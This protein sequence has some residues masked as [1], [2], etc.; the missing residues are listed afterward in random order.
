MRKFVLTMWVILFG[1]CMVKAE[2]W[3]NLQNA[4]SVAQKEYE[5][6][7]KIL[8]SRD[9]KAYYIFVN[10][11]W[12]EAFNGAE[13]TL[14]IMYPED[15]FKYIKARSRLD[16]LLYLNFIANINKGVIA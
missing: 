5:E 10:D 2:G 13:K 14:R 1:F 9:E 16:E 8:K 11:R 4:I 3:E 6:A 15:Y 12:S 7:D